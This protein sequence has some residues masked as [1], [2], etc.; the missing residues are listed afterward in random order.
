MTLLFLLMPS[1]A[2]QRID[3]LKVPQGNNTNGQAH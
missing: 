1:D 3:G 2:L